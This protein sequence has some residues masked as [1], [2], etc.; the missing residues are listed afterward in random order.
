MLDTP[1][2]QQWLSG[3]PAVGMWPFPSFV[4]LLVYREIFLNAINDDAVI[5]LLP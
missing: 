1:E 5:V 3:G 4:A 2:E